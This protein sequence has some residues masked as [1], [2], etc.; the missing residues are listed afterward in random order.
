MRKIKIGVVGA[1]NISTSAHLPAYAQYDGA[2]VVA[3]ADISEE[4][5]KAAAEK[6]GIPKYY[7]SVEAMLDNEDI[8]AVDICVWNNGHAP[9]AIEAAKRGKHV[10]CE[11]P[12]AMNLEHALEMQKAIK[13]SGVRFLLAVPG[14]F[15]ED[16]MK[17]RELYEAGEFGE[18]YYGKTAYI[19]RRGTPTG[20]FTD[21]KTSGGGPVVD[22][23]VHRIDAAWYIM[24]CPKPTRVSAATS[25]KIGDY[26]TLGVSKWQGTPCPDNQFD[27][28]D[29]GAGAIHFENG[30]VLI[31]EA[32]WAI[33]GPDHQDTQVCGSKGGIV[34]DSKLTFY[35]ENAEGYLHTEELT[36]EHPHSPTYN[37]IAHFC[38][39]IREDKETKFPIEEAVQLQ[40]MLQGIYDS[41]SLGKEVVL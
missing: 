31:F 5:A 35:G 21:K 38:D 22:I 11:K 20:W 39:C 16:N 26:Q 1:G 10:M 32:S 17:A 25:Y 23:G 37:E 3:I 34:L 41:A 14:R 2:E 18:V 7:T 8:E 19:R 28:E 36:V 33:N 15:R 6:F 13:E 24:G 29:M 40:Q 9:V 27:T 12:L 4:R 30:A